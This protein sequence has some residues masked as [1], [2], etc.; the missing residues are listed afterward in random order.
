L[1]VAIDIELHIDAAE[2]RRRE[3]DVK[4]VGALLSPGGDR[5][6]FDGPGLERAGADRRVTAARRFP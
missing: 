6:G 4:L 1:A 2:F 5:D 3:L